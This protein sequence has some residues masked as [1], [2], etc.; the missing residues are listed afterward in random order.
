MKFIHKFILVVLVLVTLTSCNDDN[1]KATLIKDHEMGLDGI[2]DFYSYN[3]IENLGTYKTGPVSVDIESV[4]TIKGSI[5]KGIKSAGEEEYQDMELISFLTRF[6]LNESPDEINENL[7]FNSKENLHLATHTGEKIDMPH[8]KLSSVVGIDML[9]S[10][11]E[12]EESPFLRIFIFEVEELAA[13]EIEAATLIIDAPVDS[14]GNAVGEDL[15]IEIDFK[16]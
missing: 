12:A 7:N 2:G 8:S 13:Q 9:K 1:G 3:K 5:T 4:E 16:E 6:D 14:E 11:H 15:E 10:N